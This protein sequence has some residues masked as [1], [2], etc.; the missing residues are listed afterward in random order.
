MFVGCVVRTRDHLSCLLTG[1]AQS[2][3]PFKDSSAGGSRD[4]FSF[5]S[6]QHWEKAAISP[7][8]LRVGHL[9]SC[10]PEGSK[11]FFRTFLKND[12]EATG[13]SRLNICSPSSTS[14]VVKSNFVLLAFF[15]LPFFFIIITHCSRSDLIY[16]AR[17]RTLWMKPSL[18]VFRLSATGWIY[19]GGLHYFNC[20]HRPQV[21]CVYPELLCQQLVGSK[22]KR[23]REKKKGE[24]RRE[25]KE[26]EGG[27]EGEKEWQEKGC[28]Q[29]CAFE[30]FSTSYAHRLLITLLVDAIKQIVFTGDLM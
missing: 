24:R 3:V 22:K 7:P 28:R 8:G 21:R 9:D 20:P 27:R 13:L 17:G 29:K 23:E 25:E 11:R 6:S 19:F 26:R 14:P 12:F 4:E 15:F 10:V 5:L 30:Y 16:W 1:L 18:N 2:L